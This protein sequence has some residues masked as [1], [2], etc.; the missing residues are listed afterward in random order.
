MDLDASTLKSPLLQQRRRALRDHVKN[1]LQ[2][3]RQKI[4][5]ATSMGISE[6]A[7]QVLPT[8]RYP[9]PSVLQTEIIEELKRKNFEA[10]AL[11]NF[12]VLIRWG[13]DKDTRS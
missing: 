10:Q 3:I 12:S 13:D 8:F 7:Y 5:L 6:V 1:E 4:L 2:L 11:A 9:D